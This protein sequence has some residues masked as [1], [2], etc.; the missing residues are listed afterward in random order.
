MAE[1]VWNEVKKYYIDQ[2][3]KHGSVREDAVYGKLL[4]GIRNLY[5]QIPTNTSPMTATPTPEKRERASSML[6]QLN[7]ELTEVDKD[8]FYI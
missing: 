1:E 2:F 5:S 7:S 3:E 6:K 8:F 4:G